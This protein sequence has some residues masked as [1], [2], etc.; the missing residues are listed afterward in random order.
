MEL[1]KKELDVLRII[2][3]KEL[4]SM[5]KDAANVMISNAGFLTKPENG[6]DLEFLKQEELYET[7]LKDLL[8]KLKND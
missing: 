4:E 1:T 5:Q 8:N 2:V 3:E 6:N 7:F